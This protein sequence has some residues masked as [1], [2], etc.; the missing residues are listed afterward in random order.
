MPAQHTPSPAEDPVKERAHFLELLR[1]FHNAMLVTH[2]SE[3]RLRA[4][5]MAV[6]KIEEDG[7]MW[8]LTDAESAK[9]HEIEKDTRVHIVCQNDRS[10]YLSLSGHAELVHDRAKVDDVW[11]EP[12]KVWFPGGKDDP[13]IALIS[14]V[15][16][17]GEYWD[18]EGTNKFKYLFEAAKSYVTGHV[19]EVKE[20]EQ[21]GRVPL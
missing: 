2:K 9:A 21:H 1:Q 16:E 15:P 20:G 4:R 13:H 3:D 19:P 17:D 6:A 11:K 10:A 18:N 7:R 8:F 5:P 14:V 12:Y